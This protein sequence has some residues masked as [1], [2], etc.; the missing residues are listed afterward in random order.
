MIGFLLLCSTA[1]ADNTNLPDYVDLLEGQRAP[2]TGKLFTED[3]LIKII[4]GHEN[5][6]E[7][8]KIDYEFKIE[9]SAADFK[10]KHDLLD[11]RYKSETEMYKTMIQV[12]DDQLKKDSKKDVLQRW[13]IYGSF[14]LGA[15]TTVA[16]VHAV[17]HV[18]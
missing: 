7:K 14:I 11:L 10:L 12:R 16:V 9:K 17:D 13:G 5:E 6:I 8:L 18:E 15:L 1:F 3:A 2:Y 4:V